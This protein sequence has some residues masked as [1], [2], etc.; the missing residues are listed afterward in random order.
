MAFLEAIL[1]L[2]NLYVF[3]NK[4]IKIKGVCYVISSKLWPN[5]SSECGF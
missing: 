2:E 3:A 4:F 1:R 5:E